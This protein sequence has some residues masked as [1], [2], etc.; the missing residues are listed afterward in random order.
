[1]KSILVAAAFVLAGC[2]GEMPATDPAGAAG[3]PTPEPT[4]TP[5]PVPPASPSPTPVKD[6]APPKL[7]GLWETEFDVPGSA[8][9]TAT[10]TLSEDRYLV[11]TMGIPIQG[12]IAVQG[13]RIE[14]FD[15]DA[16]V[17]RGEYLWSVEGGLLTF[18]LIRDGCPGRRTLL[19]GA[20][21]R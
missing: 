6:P 7:Q 2:A 10:L 14:F 8:S 19:D 15:S 1:M 9:G 12:S 3:T 16:C 4:S 18:T 13:D 21:F 20:T 11:N 5:E 17:G